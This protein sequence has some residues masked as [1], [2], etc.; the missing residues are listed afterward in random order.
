VDSSGVGG[1][2]NAHVS[3]LNSGR[4]FIVSGI[5]QRVRALFRMTKVE[6]I[7]TTFPSLR[8]A[9]EDPALDLASSAADTLR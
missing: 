4:R 8:V 1:V 2:I 3:R 5:T 7:L 9:Q 6:Q